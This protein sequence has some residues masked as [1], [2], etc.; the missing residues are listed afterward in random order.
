MKLR[1]V[2]NGLERGVSRDLTVEDLEGAVRQERTVL[3]IGYVGPRDENED[4]E[5]TGSGSG[6]AMMPDDSWLVVGGVVSHDQTRVA[7]GSLDSSNI[8]SMVLPS[9]C[10]RAK[11]LVSSAS[12]D[13]VKPRWV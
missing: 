7:K 13:R 12:R 1:E 9:M 4:E 8:P 10:A 6:A 11:P 5:P 2:A 3:R